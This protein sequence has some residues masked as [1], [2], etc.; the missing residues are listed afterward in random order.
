MGASRRLVTGTH[1]QSDQI[2]AQ[3]F[4]EHVEWGGVEDILHTS[5]GPW[6]PSR[7][8][9]SWRNITLAHP[10]LWSIIN[11]EGP[12]AADVFLNDDPPGSTPKTLFLLNLALE[13]S[14]SYPLEV[15]L[16]FD[17]HLTD[18]NTTALHQNLIRA[19]V[20]QSNRWRTADLHVGS[21]FVPCFAPIRGRLSTL[22]KLSLATFGDGAPEEFLYAKIAPCLSDIALIGYH[23]EIVALP[24]GSIRRFSETSLF[25]NPDDFKRAADQ[26]KAYLSLLR[27]NP[28]LESLEVTYPEPSPSSDSPESTQTHLA[29]RRLVTAEGNLIRSLT[30]PHLEEL[31]LDI[32]NDDTVPAIRELL[33]RSKCSLRSLRLINFTFDEDVLAILSSSST[34]QTLI[35]RLTSWD[36]GHGETMQRLMTKF[37]EPSFL[38]C[39]QDLDIIISRDYNA[40]PY[41]TAPSTIGFVDDAFVAI[42]AARWARRR[43]AGHAHLQRVFVLVELPA[44]V[45]LSKTRGVGGLQKM[46][47]EGL[48]V[49]LRARDPR[50]LDLE[51]D[52]KDISYVYPV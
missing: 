5:H 38:P 13:R 46:C 15:T 31:V 16:R 25:P 14:Q 26:T 8:C 24:W 2:L 42:L 10:E 29:L 3:I 20:A 18:D 7:I 43:A 36:K 45:G 22:T 21:A 11:V 9:R 1:S 49:F 27:N 32:E 17:T 47:D 41:L 23:H 30:L 28:R 48:D 44:T 19:V 6:V 37:A 4:L 51:Q 52:A 12:D 35:V 39:L 50:A 40:S 33:A 34:L